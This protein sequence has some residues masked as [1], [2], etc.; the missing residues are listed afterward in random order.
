MGPLFFLRGAIFPPSACIFPEAGPP[1]FAQKPVHPSGGRDSNSLKC[2][3]WNPGTR[4]AD[5]QFR[6]AN[7][8]L[9]PTPWPGNLIEL[10]TIME[11]P[12][13]STQSQAIQTDHLLPRVPPGFV[14]HRVERSG[15]HKAVVEFKRSLIET[16]L[17]QTEWNRTRAAKS[18]GL[19][20]TYLLRL[21]RELRVKALPSRRNGRSLLEPVGA[22]ERESKRD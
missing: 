1:S 14:A 8:G 4:I 19:Q 9:S 3:G 22:R 21:M 10:E 12:A 16:T 7:G 5:K 17:R 13:I 2:H 18:L 15:F 11:R 6:C 20:R